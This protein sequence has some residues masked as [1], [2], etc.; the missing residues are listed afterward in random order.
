WS[1]FA[2]MNNNFK[3]PKNFKVQ[4]S[5]TYQSKTNLPVNQGGGGFGGP[6][7][8]GGAQSAA[9]GYIHSNWGIDAALQKNFL[10][11][12]AASLTLSVSDIFRTR[13]YDVYSESQFF[14]QNSHRLN[15]V[16]MFRLNFSLR[17]GQMDL[18]LFKRKNTKAEQEGQ[19]GAMQGMGQ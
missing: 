1:Y 15:D 12:Q 6:R 9:Q 16:P 10:K 8:G 2:K 13:R 3:L 5:G 19:Q 4:L 7:M 17:F 11:N 18:T 14:I